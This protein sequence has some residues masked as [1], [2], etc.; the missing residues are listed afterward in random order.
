MTTGRSAPRKSQINLFFFQISSQILTWTCNR[1]NGVD[2]G[3][4]GST[5]YS[6]PAPAWD[7]SCY[8]HKKRQKGVGPAIPDQLSESVWAHLRCGR[9][10][11][12]TDD[13]GLDKNLLHNIAKIQMLCR[14]W[15]ARVL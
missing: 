14:A 4:K 6:A 12:D 2:V 8:E 3:A 13:I 9:A 5:K 11:Q 7:N 10:Y 15:S 1:A